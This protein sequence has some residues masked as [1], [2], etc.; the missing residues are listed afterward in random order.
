VPHPSDYE[1]GYARLSTRIQVWEASGAVLQIPQ[2]KVM[3]A[4]ACLGL[5]RPEQAEALIRGA[6]E[7]IR[8]NRSLYV[9]GRGTSSSR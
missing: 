9:R 7:V 1:E 3:L 8:Q 4:Q 6:I 5:G 2:I